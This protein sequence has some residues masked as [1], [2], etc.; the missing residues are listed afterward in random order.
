MAR[1]REAAVDEHAGVLAPGEV[2]DARG[3]LESLA[4]EPL[5]LTFSS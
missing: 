1:C 2:F 5:A 3:F 4:P